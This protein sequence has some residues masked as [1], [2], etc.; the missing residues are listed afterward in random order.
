M[1][2]SIVDMKYH[3]MEKVFATMTNAQGLVVGALAIERLWK[4]FI[5]GILECPYSEQEREEVVRL[6]EKCLDLIWT[7]IKRTSA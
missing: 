3:E 4:P 7:C 6:E 1:N 2:P 5:N